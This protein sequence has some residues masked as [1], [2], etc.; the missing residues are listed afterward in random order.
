MTCDSVL[1]QGILDRGS[2]HNVAVTCRSQQGGRLSGTRGVVSY[3]P[4]EIAFARETLQEKGHIRLLQQPTLALVEDGASHATSCP[5]QWVPAGMLS[6]RYQSTVRRIEDCSR[7]DEVRDRVDEFKARLSVGSKTLH[8]Q[9]QRPV[10][11]VQQSQSPIQENQV[12]HR[13]SG[14]QPKLV[15]W[16]EKKQQ[17]LGSPWT[18]TLQAREEAFR[19]TTP[20]CDVNATRCWAPRVNQRTAWRISSVAKMSLI[21][22]SALVPVDAGPDQIPSSSTLPAQ[23]VLTR[24]SGHHVGQHSIAATCRSQQRGRPL[25]GNLF[26]RVPQCVCDGYPRVQEASDV[27]LWFSPRTTSVCSSNPH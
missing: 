20:N 12:F 6:L 22:L 11:A 9:S 1:G 10:E 5:M 2:G 23:R 8:A 24:K 21:A 25:S 15:E 4:F 14:D 3:D 18:G 17:M 19:T 7:Q 27:S 26:R 13:P 16:R